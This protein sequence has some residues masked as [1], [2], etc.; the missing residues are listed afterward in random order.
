MMYN[1]RQWN[2]VTADATIYGATINQ[3]KQTHELGNVDLGDHILPYLENID[4]YSPRENRR[5]PEL[6]RGMDS[7]NDGGLWLGLRVKE[8]HKMYIGR[9][10]KIFIWS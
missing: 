4:I 8:T 2:D 1:R 5:K 10:K 3:R 7:I 9:E 6:R